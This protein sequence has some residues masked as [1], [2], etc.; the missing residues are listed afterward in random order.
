[1]QKVIVI[2][3]VGSGTVISQAIKDA[4]TRGYNDIIV[5][6]F[7]ND[8][9]KP[10][11]MI[12]G[13]PVIAK[14]GKENVQ[15]YSE[16]GYK[17]IYTLHG[18]DGGMEFVKLFSDLGLSPDKLVTFIHPTAYIAPDVEVEAGV[19]IM[20][21]VMI[22]SHATIGLNS[23]IMTGVT[24]GHN[25]MLGKFNHI[26]S[27]AVVGAHIKTEIGVHFGLNS[28]VREHIF[29]DKYST[30]GMGAVLVENVKEREIWVGNPAKLLRLAK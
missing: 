8:K 23:L 10:G 1:M 3:G 20:P 28:T 18:T 19:V 11:E 6:G 4:N 24:I 22:S 25:T 21:Y 15:I 7:F 12:E 2:G 30:V 14:T 5:D 16:K 29:L 17:F 13:F 27:Q 9:I 26:A